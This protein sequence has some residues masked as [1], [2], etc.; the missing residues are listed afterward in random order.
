MHQ[1]LKINVS[2]ET[3][4]IFGRVLHNKR[5]YFRSS[6]KKIHNI[7]K[8]TFITLFINCVSNFLSSFINILHNFLFK[9]FTEL[10]IWFHEFS[11]T[12]NLRIFQEN[13]FVYL[14]FC[15]VNVNNNGSNEKRNSL[16][17]ILLS[18]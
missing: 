17:I 2:K 16:S 4:V 18:N 11:V 10:L 7:Q 3:V 14:F 8:H 5:N 6:E 15:T 1:L 13:E 9:P 12:T